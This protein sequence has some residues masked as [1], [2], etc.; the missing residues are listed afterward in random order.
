MIKGFL[1]GGFRPF[2]KGHEALIDYA[3][4][5]CDQLI[6]FVADPPEAWEIPWKYRV[7]WVSSQ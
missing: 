7:N 5:N 3:K 6:I 4:A 1:T 2:H